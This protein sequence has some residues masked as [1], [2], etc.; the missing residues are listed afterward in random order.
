MLS[1]HLELLKKLNL[2]IRTQMDVAE[3]YIP[4]INL[5]LHSRY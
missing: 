2:S 1:K 4:A 3:C 5:Q